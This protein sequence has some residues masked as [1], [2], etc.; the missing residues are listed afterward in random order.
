[1]F[2]T[3]EDLLKIIKK[4]KKTYKQT[5]KWAKNVRRQLTK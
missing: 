1:M 3:Q 5:G 2:M 4:K